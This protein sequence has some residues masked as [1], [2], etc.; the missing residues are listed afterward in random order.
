MC[1]TGCTS[2]EARGMVSGG[3]GQYIDWVEAPYI[4]A[5]LGM[6]LAPA[7]P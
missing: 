7:N 3:N 2:R 5:T 1:N 4:F 6:H